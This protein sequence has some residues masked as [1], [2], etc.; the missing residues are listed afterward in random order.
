M[1]VVIPLSVVTP[2]SK[3]PG[4]HLH[5]DDHHLKAKQFAWLAKLE[6]YKPGIFRLSDTSVDV[7]QGTN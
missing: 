4:N 1:F 3:N 2:L 5:G 6:C 7:H